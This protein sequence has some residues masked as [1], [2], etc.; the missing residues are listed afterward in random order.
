MEELYYQYSKNKGHDQLRGNSE[1]DLRLGFRIC[2]NLFFSLRS[3]FEILG[4]YSKHVG[5]LNFRTFTV[6]FSIS[7]EDNFEVDHTHRHTLGTH[8]LSSK[9]R[10]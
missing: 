6:G 7:K 8:V 4:D 9:L 1:A 5:V 3:L 10:H 2:K